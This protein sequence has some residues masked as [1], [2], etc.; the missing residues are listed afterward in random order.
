MKIKI[1]QFPPRPFP[2]FLP[3]QQI[4]IPDLPQPKTLTIGI[5]PSA[6]VSF[7]IRQDRRDLSQPQ[8]RESEKAQD[9]RS[10]TE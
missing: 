10:K 8:V 5:P 9:R 4:D 1:P 2:P 3:E 6:S 7:D